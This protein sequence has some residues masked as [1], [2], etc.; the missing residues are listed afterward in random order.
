MKG[1]VTPE[2]QAQNALDATP[3]RMNPQV[4]EFLVASERV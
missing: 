2:D 3:P 4:E 1:L